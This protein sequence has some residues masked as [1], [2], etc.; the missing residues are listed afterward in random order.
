MLNML[1]ISPLRLAR[2]DEHFGGF[3]ESHTGVY[4]HIKQLPTPLLAPRENRISLLPNYLTVPC[5]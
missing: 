3:A 5:G 1:S 2:A 4:G